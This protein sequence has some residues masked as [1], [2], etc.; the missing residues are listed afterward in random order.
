MVGYRIWRE[1]AKYVKNENCTLWDLGYGKK[2]D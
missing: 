2:T 1:T